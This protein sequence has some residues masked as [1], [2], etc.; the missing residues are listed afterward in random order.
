MH[1]KIKGVVDVVRRETE[2]TLRFSLDVVTIGVHGQT[3]MMLKEKSA[4]AGIEHVVGADRI[5]DDRHHRPFARRRR[6][7]EIAFAGVQSMQ[8]PGPAGMEK[9]LIVV[10]IETIEVR[11][12]AP[13]RLLDAQYL[14]TP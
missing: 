14:S 8:V 6:P 10:E 3:V 12:L 7:Q 5:L 9:F 1:E 11:A 4:A 13:G 2:L